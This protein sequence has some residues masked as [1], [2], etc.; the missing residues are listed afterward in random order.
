MVYIITIDGAI[1]AGKSSLI[2]QL[3][4]DFTCF[5]EPVEEWSLLQNFYENMPEFAAPFQYQVLFSFHKLYS[6]FKNVQD[7]VILERCPWSSKNIFTQLL[8]ESGHI[9]QEEYQLYC[10]FYNKIAFTTNLYVYL[11]VD[12]DV[13]YRRILNRDRAAER[14]LTFEYLEILNNKYNDSLKTLENVKIIDANK[15]LNEIKY[16]VIDLLRKI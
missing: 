8:V 2:S 4:D 11:K 1:G 6:T 16:E 5:Q 3:K 15:P 13:A 9:S 14:S 12:T 7:K 10:N